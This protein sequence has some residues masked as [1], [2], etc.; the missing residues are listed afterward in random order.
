MSLVLE[1]TENGYYGSGL[2]R[3]LLFCEGFSL[4]CSAVAKAEGSFSIA[5]GEPK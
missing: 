2:N 5:A 4:R 3:K 1:E